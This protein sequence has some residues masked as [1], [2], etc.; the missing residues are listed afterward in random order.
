M[1]ETRHLRTLRAIAHSG[2]FAA[3]ARQ[4][5]CTQPA[6]SQQMK[7]LELA[8]GTPLL[9]RTSREVRVTEA[10]AA[11]VRRSAGVLAA[12][13]AAEE[14]MAA[15]AG[16]R[17]GRVRLTSFL[18]GTSA[19]IPSAIAAMR[20]AHPDMEVSLVEAPPPRS[21]DLLR[22][23][24]CDI[25]LA[26]RY[27]EIP[28]GGAK[29]QGEW[30]DLAV[31]PLLADPLVVLVPE[32]HRLAEMGQVELVELADESWVMG[33]DCCRRHLLQLCEHAG[34]EPRAE[35]K[36]DDYP[37]V[38]GLVAAGLGVAVLPELAFSGASSTGIRLL[39]LEPTVR[40]EVVALSMLA[41]A[42]V[43][44]VGLMLR[45]LERSAARLPRTSSVRRSRQ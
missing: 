39:R 19:L 27:P 8:M 16:L 1:I 2:S 11:L 29:K 43:P 15:F 10:G 42:T 6:V 34:F 33:C 14:E 26:F 9:V 23:A 5:G 13:H 24:D 17:T 21:I 37:T 4:L 31:R 45:E 18:S 41:S 7:S 40:R 28:G 12:L 36:T 44:A 38:I 30:Q 20:A 25:A 22:N 32:G 35:Y 3:A